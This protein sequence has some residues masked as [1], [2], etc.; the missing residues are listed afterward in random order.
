M[1]S[2]RV[3]CLHKIIFLGE[4]HLRRTITQHLVHYCQEGNH[5]SLD[6]QLIDPEELK[7]IGPIRRLKRIDGLLSSYYREAA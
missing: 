5:H 7:P 2:I 1:K 3:E 4:D 6:N